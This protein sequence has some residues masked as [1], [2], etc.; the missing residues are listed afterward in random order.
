MSTL[1]TFIQHSTGNPSHSNQ[2]TKRNRRHP[3]QQRKSKTFTICGWHDTIYICI[4]N[5]K[6]PTKKLLELINKFNIVIQ[7]FHTSP[8]AHHNCK[9]AGY[10]ANVP[11]RWKTYILKTV[12]HVWKKLKVTQRNGKTFYAHEIRNTNTVKISTLLK[13]I[14]TFNAIPIKTPTVFTEVEQS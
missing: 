8:R 7:H 11:K 1:I 3:N 6:N 10:K 5:L 2:T 12:K 13:A 14:Y 4:E 9:V